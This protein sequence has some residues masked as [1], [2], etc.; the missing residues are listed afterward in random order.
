M[1][2][3]AIVEE[4]SAALQVPPTSEGYLSLT[5]ISQKNIPM[6]HRRCAAASF[7]FLPSFSFLI[8]PQVQFLNTGGGTE[9]FHPNLYADGKVCISLLGT[10]EGDRAERWDPLNSCI[11]QVLVSIQSLILGEYNPNAIGLHVTVDG[12]LVSRDDYH[13]YRIATIRYAMIAILQG[14]RGAGPYADMFPEFAPI[15]RAYFSVN[16]HRLMTILQADYRDLRRSMSPKEQRFL[17]EVTKL[18]DEF[19]IIDND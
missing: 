2:R 7:P 4:S 10:F 8:H 13:D 17:R 12:R 14:C 1:T 11:G 5:Y 3:H 9:R 15:I 18:V 6:F 19:R 16:R